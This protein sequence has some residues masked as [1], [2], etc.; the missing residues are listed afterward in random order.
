M[1]VTGFPVGLCRWPGK[2]AGFPLSAGFL[3]AVAPCRT[4]PSGHCLFGSDA[5]P[6]SRDLD[7]SRWQRCDSHS[8]PSGA[9]VRGR[10]RRRAPRRLPATSRP[11]H[12][13]PSA[14]PVDFP[15][16]TLETAARQTYPPVWVAGDL[17]VDVASSPD[18]L[19]FVG[20]GRYMAAA[21]MEPRAKCV[22]A[23]RYGGFTAGQASCRP[24]EHMLK[25]GDP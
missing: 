18:L 7:P 8:V 22:D 10:A 19:S 12:P 3:P 4:A 15:R 23:R 14:A 20:F 24:P 2:P 25:P 21:Y 6:K 17:P 1:R 5:E 16:C 11:R 9:A 13:G